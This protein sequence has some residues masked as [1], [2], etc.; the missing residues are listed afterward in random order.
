[1]G[2]LPK[3]ECHFLLHGIILISSAIIVRGTTT[4]INDS[5]DEQIGDFAISWPGILV[6]YFW[7]LLIIVSYENILE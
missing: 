5:V 4:F 2:A 7:I 6:I 1:M 3:I